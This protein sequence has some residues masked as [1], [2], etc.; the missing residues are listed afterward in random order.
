MKDIKNRKSDKPR[1]G[2][3]IGDYN[4]IGP[5]VI[6]KVLQDKRITNICTPVVY[7]SGRILTKYKR[8]LGIEEFTYH[9]YNNNSYLHDQKINVVNCWTEVQE[10][11]PGKITEEAGKCAYLS[12]ARASED[13]NTKT[14]DAVVTAPINKA[15]IQSEDFKHAGH[16]EYYQENHA[17]GGDTLMTLC[18]GSLRVGVVTGH[19][20]LKDVSAAITKEALTSKLKVLINS[21]KKDFGI[22]KPKVAIMGLNPHAGEDGLL[23]DEE[24]NVI[25]PVVKEFK[26]RGNLV[27]GPFP[28][29]G[30]FGTMAFKNYDG[31]LC[32]Y[33]DQ[34]L[35]PFKLHAFESGV[36]Y[37]AG[38]TIVRTSPDHGT[39]YNI[40][41]KGV[42]DETSFREALMQAVDIVKVRNGEITNKIRPNAK[43]L[44]QDR[45]DQIKI[46]KTLKAGEGEEEF[47][48]SELEAG[49]RKEAQVTKQQKML[50]NK[51]KNQ[52][53]GGGRFDR[54]PHNKKE[55]WKPRKNHQDRPPFPNKSEEAPREEKNN[56]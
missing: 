35:I 8:I 5:E 33:H 19:I 23:G 2:I 30:F 36:N 45:K 48:L 6:V 29:D 21:L 37:T 50:E 56:G 15:N 7:G 46:Q 51:S 3:T 28:A 31:V 16:T 10:L 47:D 54:R 14:I 55:H 11:E 41:G 22:T 38:L 20:P 40:A 13:L 34:G 18:A 52:Q 26:K 9:Q 27:F 42:A 24:I 32:M 44:L 12:I 4:G 17:D 53:Q 1:I 43:Q 39:A 25:G 49:E